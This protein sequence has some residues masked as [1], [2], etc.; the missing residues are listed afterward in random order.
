VSVISL[1][2][3]FGTSDWFVGTMKGV[4]LN[5]HPRAHIVDLSHEIPAGD[6][7][8][9]AFALACGYR[10]FPEG[11]IHV[12]IVDPGVGGP[13]RAIAVRTRH[14]TFVGPDNGVLS[15]ALAREKVRSVRLLSNPKLHRGTTSHTFH[16]RDVFAPVAAHL[17]ARAAFRKLGPRAG[18]Y[19]QLAWPQ[20]RVTGSG[21]EGEV[22]QIDRFGNAIT[23][24]EAG[25][26]SHFSAAGIQLRGRD[27]CRV[28]TF[29][30]AVPEGDP[31]GVIGSSG[32]L[33]LAVRGGSAARTLGLK[34][35]S[36][37]Q[38]RFSAP[39]SG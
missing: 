31:V 39:P 4:I 8:G 27:V 37:V 22:V 38:L 16:G 32:F 10:F 3:D 9:G 7:R 13:R 33:E 5:I 19:V 25:H 29:Y 36:P 6:I 11:T 2:T 12:A 14:Y 21:V 30:A 18:S 35:G 34:R 24:I 20:P 1:T 15:L 23:N 17:A 26:L 28:E